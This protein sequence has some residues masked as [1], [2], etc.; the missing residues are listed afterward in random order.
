MEGVT[1]ECRV[2]FRENLIDYNFPPA[3]RLMVAAPEL[4][5]ALEECCRQL[6]MMRLSADAQAAYLTGRAALA[7]ATGGD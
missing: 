3:A 5:E 4:E 1:A 7:K 6:D 2:T